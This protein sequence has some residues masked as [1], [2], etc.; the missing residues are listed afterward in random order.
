MPTGV[1]GSATSDMYS[2]FAVGLRDVVTDAL[3]NTSPFF[4]DVTIGN[5]ELEGDSADPYLV[6]R[7]R[8]TNYPQHLFLLRTRV[9]EYE[10]N[11][12]DPAG[13]KAYLF[14]R[15][16]ETVDAAPGLCPSNPSDATTLVE[17]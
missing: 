7:L 13:W 5:V 8:R 14:D 3:R 17:F 16:M 4:T 11:D 15:V 12:T 6:I 2:S 1:R 10:E 9:R